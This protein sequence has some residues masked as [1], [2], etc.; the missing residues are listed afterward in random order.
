MSVF[1]YYISQGSI[2]KHL[3]CGGIS[4]IVTFLQIYCRICRWKILCSYDQNLL[5]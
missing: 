4:Q 2:A 1:E 5:A 3:M